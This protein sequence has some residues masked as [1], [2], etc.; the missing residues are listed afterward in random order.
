LR[1]LLYLAGALALVRAIVFA[2]VLG[3]QGSSRPRSL[4]EGSSSPD[5]EG[6][7]RLETPAPS[8]S[9]SVR[10]LIRR[11]RLMERPRDRVAVEGL[12]GLMRGDGPGGSAEE[13]TT[14]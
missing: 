5:V 6:T 1:R 13:G 7:P 9:A 11:T 14:S 3:R 4:E 12:H 10:D 2:Y 8:P